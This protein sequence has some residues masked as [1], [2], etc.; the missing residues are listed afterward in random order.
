MDYGRVPG[1]DA[2]LGEPG[3][4]FAL[5]TRRQRVGRLRASLAS[6]KEAGLCLFFGGRVFSESD[7]AALQANLVVFPASNEAVI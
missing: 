7:A 5:E 4:H 6:H 3:G 1:E 2:V